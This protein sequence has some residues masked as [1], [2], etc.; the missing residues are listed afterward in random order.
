EY[1]DLKLATL[2]H[3]RDNQ[4]KN[5]EHVDDVKPTLSRR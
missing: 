5:A 3:H 1:G 2:E 4:Q